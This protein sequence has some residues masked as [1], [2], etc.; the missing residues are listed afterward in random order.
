MNTP[1]GR[2]Y[3][4]T[5]YFTW[6]L[7]A[8]L[9]LSLQPACAQLAFDREHAFQ[10]G[11]SDGAGPGFGSTLTAAGSALFGV[12]ALGG[13]SNSG[14]L[15]MIGT[16]LAGVHV[17]HG[18][19]GYGEL[20]PAGSI[21]DGAYAY[22]TPLLVG[23]MLYGTT[24]FGGTNG[25]GTIYA[26]NTNGT[27]FA[28]LH[29]F[30]AAGD[31]YNPFGSLVLSGSTLFGLAQEGTNGITAGTLFSLNTNGTGYQTLYTFGPGGHPYGALLVAGSN[32]YGMSYDGGSNNLDA[33]ILGRQLKRS[34]GSLFVFRPR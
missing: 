15:F 33:E 17:L 14:A 21:N 8:A 28:I 24:A 20:N 30:G 12:T 13:V 26:I 25:L 19:N 31:G 2:I 29:H 27:G 9:A 34:F 22:G 3:R 4:F 11:A 32:L 5:R 7:L 16:N 6:L 18:F 1:L 23:S 10:G